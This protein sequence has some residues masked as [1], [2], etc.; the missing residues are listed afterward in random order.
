MIPMGKIL[1]NYEIMKKNDHIFIIPSRNLLG[2][3]CNHVHVT[4]HLLVSYHI[5]GSMVLRYFCLRKV[6]RA[7]IDI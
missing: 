1:H 3:L 5:A 6:A 2:K 4:P 7:E